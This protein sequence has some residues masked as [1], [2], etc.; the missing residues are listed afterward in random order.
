[1]EWLCVCVGSC[2]IEWLCVCVCVSAVLDGMLDVLDGML[3]V[4]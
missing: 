3:D 4:G 1:M 2:G